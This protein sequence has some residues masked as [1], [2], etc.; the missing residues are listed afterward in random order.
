MN[1][2]GMTAA[3]TA[4]VE[5]G[6]LFQFGILSYIMTAIITQSVSVI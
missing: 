4:G 3:F 6:F 1:E 5:L 2:E